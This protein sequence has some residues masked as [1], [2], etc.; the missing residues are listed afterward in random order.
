M[1]YSFTE[2]DKEVKEFKESI[3]FGVHK[4]QFLGA[5]AEE[6]DAGKDFIAVGIV[7]EDGIE[8]EARLWFVG[9]ASNISFNTLRAIVVH[10]AKE[11]DKEKAGAE[12]DACK[13]TQELADLLI[14]YLEG[15][16]ELWYTKFYDPKRTYT[17]DNGTFRSINK[18]IYSYPP[19]SRPDLMPNPEAEAKTADDLLEEPFQSGT[20]VDATTKAQ[21]P[22]NWAK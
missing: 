19:K 15:G 2:E 10:N 4:V 17:T 13:D 6:T 8:D 1:S 18:N 5:T 11:A 7:S 21:I 3:S 16:G 14:K 12:A 9:G 20:P 22:D